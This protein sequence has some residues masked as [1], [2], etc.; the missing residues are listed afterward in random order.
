M[1]ISSHSHRDVLVLFTSFTNECL[2]HTT[3]TAV[4]EEEAN[5]V[6]FKVLLR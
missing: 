2:R 4:E 3:R 1:T 5:V 6:I